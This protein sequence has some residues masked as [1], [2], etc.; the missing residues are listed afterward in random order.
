MRQDSSRPLLHLT[1]VHVA[2][3]RAYL[4][5]LDEAALHAHYGV[6]V[7]NLRAALPHMADTRPQS[8]SGWPA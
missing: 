5:G 4:E 6:R 1:R 2:L 8:T 7:T 3:Y